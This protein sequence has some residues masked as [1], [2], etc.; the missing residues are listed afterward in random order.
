MNHFKNI[1]NVEGKRVKSREL[2]MKKILF[3][4]WKDALKNK[5]NKLIKRKE[6]PNAIREF[7]HGK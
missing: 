5:V 2:F 3:Q 7:Y 1:M 6:K 4:G